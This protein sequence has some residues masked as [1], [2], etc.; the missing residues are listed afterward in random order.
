M[1]S[2]ITALLLALIVISFVGVAKGP[3]PFAVVPTAKANVYNIYYS[4]AEVGKVKI[5]IYNAQNELVHTEVLSNVS[6]FKRPYNFSQVAEGQYKIVVEDKS[7]K[8]VE[9]VNYAMNKVQSFISVT[10]AANAENKYILNV[11]NNGTEEISVKIFSGSNMIH[12]QALQVTGSFGLVYN[13][14]KVKTPESISFEVT[15]SNGTT[16]VIKF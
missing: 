8:H 3:V 16:Q 13:L 15:T 6:S 14:Q 12:S 9:Q 2:K 7:G 10:E 5:S 4:S 1:N 11:T